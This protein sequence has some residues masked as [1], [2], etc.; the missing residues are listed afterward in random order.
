MA[1]IRGRFAVE[2]HERAVCKQTML[3]LTP[4]RMY[5]YGR[6]HAIDSDDGIPTHHRGIWRMDDCTRAD[7][8]RI[9]NVSALYVSLLPILVSN[10][11]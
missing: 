5:F 7:A 8:P 11:S 2:D 4:K 3:C 10:I 6:Y 9:C 1:G